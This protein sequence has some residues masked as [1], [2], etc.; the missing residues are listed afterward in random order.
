MTSA[1][2]S[3]TGRAAVIPGLAKFWNMTSVSVLRAG[4]RGPAANAT[5]RGEYDAHVSF[6]GSRVR[7]PAAIASGA[8]LMQDL[9]HGVAPHLRCRA[10]RRS[11][12]CPANTFAK[13]SRT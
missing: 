6:E 7:L 4:E 5:D 11:W 3:V 10:A 12:P 13:P 8:C 1:S 2:V 9:A